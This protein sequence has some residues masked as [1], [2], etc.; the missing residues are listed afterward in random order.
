MVD[1]IVETA[2]FNRRLRLR[3]RANGYRAGTDAVLLAASAPFDPGPVVVDVGAGVGAVGLAL[4][5][6]APMARVLLVESDP[7]AVELARQNLALNALDLRGQ[8]FSTNVLVAAERRAAGLGDGTASLVLT[9]PPFFEDGTVSRSPIN[10][11]GSA[12][13]LRK[14]TDLGSWIAACLALAEAGGMFAMVHRP[15]ALPKILSACEGRLG[16]VTIKPVHARSREPAIRVLVRGI[17]GSRTPLSI[18][19]PLILHTPDGRFTEEAE[20]IHRGDALI[21]WP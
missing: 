15:E 3:Q 19:F 1:A 4:A 10:A 17:K 16:A 12:H 8:V 20:A 18:A 13:I 5:M 6:R 9:N 21:G 14:G 2:F 11:K 7:D